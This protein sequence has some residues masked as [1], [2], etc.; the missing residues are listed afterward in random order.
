MYADNVQCTLLFTIEMSMHEVDFIPSSKAARITLCCN[1]YSFGFWTVEIPWLPRKVSRNSHDP[2]S[3]PYHRAYNQRE[4]KFPSD[5]IPLQS[6]PG[7]TKIVCTHQIRD[8]FSSIPKALADY[9]GLPY[10]ASQEI[11]RG[12]KDELCH[13]NPKQMQIGSY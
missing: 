4:L 6:W 13:S 5:Q 8:G 10:Q 1:A 9:L 7:V 12:P 2:H 11:D 3:V